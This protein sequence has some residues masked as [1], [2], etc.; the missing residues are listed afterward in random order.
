MAIDPQ[1]IASIGQNAPDIAG[2]TM[3]AYTL[4]DAVNRQQLGQMQ[5]AS[6]KEEQADLAKLKTLSQDPKYSLAT[7]EGQNAYVAEAL[8]I[9]PRLGMQLQ[10][11]MNETQR[12]AIELGD[13]KIKQYQ[14]RLGVY[15]DIIAPAGGLVEQNEK[16]PVGDP[17]KLSPADLKM[18]VVSLVSPPLNAAKSQKLSY[19]E[20]VIRPEDAQQVAQLLSIQ[21]PAQFLS[22][23]KQLYDSHQGAKDKIMAYQQKKTA[24]ENLESEIESRGN[25]IETVMQNGKPMRVEFDKKG[26]QI[27]VLGEAPPTAATVQVGG[28]GNQTL[29]GELAL[30]G[31]YPPAR[32]AQAMLNGLKQSYPGKTDAEIADMV[33]TG[34]ATLSEVT[35]GLKAYDT[36]QEGKAIRSFNVAIDHL[37]TLKPLVTALQNGDIGAFNNLKNTVAKALGST[38]PTDFESVSQIVSD[39]LVKAITG[40]GGALGDREELKANFSA[41]RSPQQLLS[42]INRYTEL[43]GGQLVGLEQGYKSSTKRDDFETVKLTPG[44]RAVFE[45]HKKATEQPAQSPPAATNP[46]TRPPPPSSPSGGRGE[47]SQ[48]QQALAWANANPNDPRAA[49]IKK[50]LGAQ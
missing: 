26:N 15:D 12:G 31:I 35:S 10:K 43:M 24:L 48:D 4:A 18:R 5:L 1:S 23:F 11:Q 8:K 36:G 2:S 13:A 6:E 47:T 27:R 40:S 34:K 14:E 30:R 46:Q 37:A 3:K 38:V 20:S 41:A 32:S 28:G 49:A 21:D 42:I 33:A 9:N 22:A 45:K 19:G 39:E 50:R 17:K 44:A 29:L 16:L 7:P 25:K